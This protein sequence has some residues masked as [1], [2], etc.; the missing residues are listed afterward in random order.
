DSSSTSDSMLP[1]QSP[2]FAEPLGHMVELAQIA[3]D[4]AEVRRLVTLG[5]AA[6]STAWYLQ[7]HLAVSLGDSARRAFWAR[8]DLPEGVFSNINIFTSWTGI[9][10]GDGAR[11]RTEDV[12]QWRRKNPDFARFVQHGGALNAG[13]PKEAYL[14]LYEHVP[15]RQVLQAQINDALYWG[16]DTSA[17]VEAVRRLR[18]FAEAGSKRGDEAREQ[19]HALCVVAEWRL[20]R[21]ETQGADMA[22]RRL[23]AATVPGLVSADSAGFGRYAALCAAVLEVL[24]A[25]TL[26]KPDLRMRTERLDS[27]ARTFIFEVCCGEAV[28]GVNLVLAQ[29]WEAQGDLPRALQAVRRRAAGYGLYPRLMSTFLREEGRLAVLAGEREAAIGAYQHYLALR[30]DPEP[31]VKPEVEQVRADLA[32]LLGEQGR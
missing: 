15:S 23:R 20:A 30:P 6:D 17:A 13:R 12:R 1:Q 16:G 11:A 4:T 8:P 25:A 32:G 27:L 31:S 26:R 24:Q 22:I 21:G 5:L 9:A 7:W 14:S 28:P 18:P 29:L 19:Y 10:G 3:G 2:V